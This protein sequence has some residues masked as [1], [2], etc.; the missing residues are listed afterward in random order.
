[1]EP[2]LDSLSEEWISQPSTSLSTVSRDSLSPG[3]KS[4]VSSRSRI[5]RPKTQ[6]SS[7]SDDLEEK[8]YIAGKAAAGGRREN[9]PLLERTS[10]ELNAVGKA[11]AK[12]AVKSGSQSYRNALP[13]PIRRRASTNSTGSTQSTQPGTVQHRALRRSSPMTGCKKTTPEWKKKVLEG[14]GQGG[15]R[16]LFSPMEIEGLFKPPNTPKEVK[17]SKLRKYTST[18]E[19]ATRL[20]SPPAPQDVGKEPQ[21]MAE[22]VAKQSSPNR[23]DSVAEGERRAGLGNENA[24]DEG[25]DNPP[26]DSQPDKPGFNSSALLDTDFED[27]PYANDDSGFAQNQE[28]QS[29]HDLFQNQNS[30]D[31]QRVVSSKSEPRH[32]NMSLVSISRL[33]LGLLKQGVSLSPVQFHTDDEQ[34]AQSSLIHHNHPRREGNA[35]E[36]RVPDSDPIDQDAT[37]QYLPDGLSVGSG[38]FTTNNRFVTMHR[39]GYSTDSISLPRPL[40]TSPASQSD[41]ITDREEPDDV[42]NK[43]NMPLLEPLESPVKGVEISSPAE[44]A[45]VPKTPSKQESLEY[46]SPQR[47]WSSGSPLKLFD[48]YDTFT[49]DRLARRM[50]QFQEGMEDSDDGRDSRN[51]VDLPNPPRESLPSTPTHGTQ[52]TYSVPKVSDRR[53]SSFGDGV[54]DGHIF[55][56]E[57]LVKGPYTEDYIRR[58]DQQSQSKSIGLLRTRRA[59]S[60]SCVDPQ[61]HINGNTDSIGNNVHSPQDGILLDTQ[62]INVSKRKA[63][64]YTDSPVKDS[65][66]AKRQ[67]TLVADT[68][69][70]PRR[71]LFPEDDEQVQNQQKLSVAGRKRK[72]ARYDKTIAEADPR[73]IA[74][75][76]MLR[77][78]TPT[79]SQNKLKKRF[80]A[81]ALPKAYLDMDPSTNLKHGDIAQVLDTSTQILDE[82]L[83]DFAADVAEDNANN[84]RNH[85]VTTADF[86]NEANL[87]MQQIRA[88]GRLQ[89]RPE[90]AKTTETELLDDIQETRSEGSTVER[91]SRP[92]SRDGN[93]ITIPEERQLDPRVVSYLKKYE[94][95]DDSS[96]S[97][98]SSV[99]SLKFKENK[100]PAITD[101][102]E[103]DPPNIRI[104]DR[105]SVTLEDPG[106]ARQVVIG[107]QPNESCSPQPLSVGSTERSLPTGSSKSSGN[108]TMI[109]PEKVAHLL[110]DNVAGM[111]YDHSRKIWMKR[112]TSESLFRSQNGDS[113]YTEDDIFNEIPDLSVD[114]LEELKSIRL[115]TAASKSASNLRCVPEPGSFPRPERHSISEAGSNSPDS[116]K[117]GSQ[118]DSVFSKSSRLPLNHPRT[119]TRTTS[120]D[121][122][123]ADS[124]S[125]TIKKNGSEPINQPAQM[126]EVEHEISILEGRGDRPE[127]IF[128]RLDRR[129]RVVTTVEF[130]SPLVTYCKNQYDDEESDLDL[131]SSP[132]RPK[133]KRKTRNTV[134]IP[135]AHLKSSRWRQ[136]GRRSSLGSQVVAAYPIPSI[137]EYDGPAFPKSEG[138]GGGSRGLILSTPQQIHELYKGTSLQLRSSR[139]QS[140]SPLNLPALP[141]F[142]IHQTDEVPPVGFAFKIQSDHDPNKLDNAKKQL[143]K[144]LTDL[145]P[146]EP[147]WEATQRLDLHGRNLDTLYSLDGYCN[148]VIELNVSDNKLSQLRGAPSSVRTL[149]VRQNRLTELTTWRELHNLQYVDVSGNML[150][151]LAGFESLVHL[152]VLVAE[153]NCV[154]SLQG[155]LGMEALIRLRLGGNRLA[156][157]DFTG[158]KL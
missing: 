158:A 1:M 89:L 56:H 78:R 88:K 123:L 104:S 91:F 17:Q 27:Q 22:T 85:S 133:P 41:A 116:D 75:R 55:N 19:E 92:P 110:P 34:S 6:G 59:S 42:G 111:T 65:P 10:S 141:D 18:A 130:S 82:K 5:P 101:D 8:N 87:I 151:S 150:R 94:D 70:S 60:K 45:K 44:S 2:W 68:I 156:V 32:E 139:Q 73:V 83:A 93:R 157:A 132:E 40:S 63:K 67:R 148:Q 90:R 21:H 58:R 57:G 129:P 138:T 146:Y 26:Q 103:S 117:G 127:S 72:D 113:D 145:M 47:P 23:S 114:E 71:I 30:V 33:K 107:D 49:N 128:H 11:G 122:K 143:T 74:S 105:H 66:K 97:L 144:N 102:I 100:R 131:A 54:L 31:G 96:I 137:E 25:A 62:E 36:N 69:Q 15:Q 24:L 135:H 147:Y 118:V 125:D 106:S 4:S 95:T 134:N 43:I 13:V 39:G 7:H 52:H 142:S 61:N 124:S 120:L 126:E 64:G 80:N 109:G 48:K 12:S 9:M 115:A 99:G 14:G 79:P 76:R 38:S 50:S 16:D 35:K 77:P 28:H 37:S 86:S 29:G 112:K 121:D 20:R 152:R 53:V 98:P 140:Y 155:V 153:N 81:F 84:H 108:K 136:R 119:E 3:L 154:E 51:H 46:G 149:E